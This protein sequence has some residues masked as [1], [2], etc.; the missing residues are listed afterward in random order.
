[1]RQRSEKNKETI[2]FLKYYTQESSRGTSVKCIALA[3]PGEGCVRA[4]GKDAEDI[5]TMH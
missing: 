5:L 4:N 3:D 2:V 1:M